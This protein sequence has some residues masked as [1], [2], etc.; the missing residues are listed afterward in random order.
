MFEQPRTITFRLIDNIEGVG[1]AGQTVTMALQPSDTYVTTELDTWLAGYSQIGDYRADQVAGQVLVDKET[2]ELRYFTLGNTFRRVEVR[3]SLQGSVNEV[4]VQSELKPVGPLT[5]RALGAFVPA[6]LASQSSY[7]QRTSHASRINE[8]LAL[9]KEYRGWSLLTTSGSWNANNRVTLTTGLQWG[10]ASGAGASSNPIADILT[11]RLRSAAKI[12]EWWMNEEVGT[13]F[14][15]HAA[16]RD[17]LRQMLGDNAPS[18]SVVTEDRSDFVIPGIGTIHI[19]AAKGLN[20]STNNLE[21]I[22]NDTVLGTRSIPS[23]P[24]G[25][26]DI[27]TIKQFVVRGPSG[28]GWISR[29]VNLAARGYGG[30]EL[31]IVGQQSDM[32]MA[33]DIVGCAIFDVLQ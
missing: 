19:V 24:Q 11:Y 22:L 13:W 5:H 21:Y 17:H 10:G 9:D 28:T 26:N 15:R 1:V 23:T 18:P 7:D 25:G 2:T 4:D 12:T 3:T 32:F 14:I 27:C 29:S 30:G 8:A 20:E 33:S 16:V 31:L 6:A